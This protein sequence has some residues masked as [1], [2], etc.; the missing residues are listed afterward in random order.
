M[1]EYIVNRLHTGTPA[2]MYI[3]VELS[4]GLYSKVVVGVYVPRDLTSQ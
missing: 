3:L 1:N 2:G 4:R